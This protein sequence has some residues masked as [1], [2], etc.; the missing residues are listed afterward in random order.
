MNKFNYLTIIFLLIFNSISNAQ[1]NIRV[2]GNGIAIS[3]VGNTGLVNMYRL[4]ERTRVIG[5][6]GKQHLFD[7]RPK[8]IEGKDFATTPIAEGYWK[9]DS[10]KDYILES[11][12]ADKMGTVTIAL[13]TNELKAKGWTILPVSFSSTVDTYYLYTY[14]YT[15]PGTWVNIPKTDSSHP[16]LL[17]ADARRLKF[18]NPLPLADLAEGVLIANN[19]GY[20]VVDPCLIILPNGDYIAEC[21]VGELP[22]SRDTVNKFVHHYLSKDKGKTWTMLTKSSVGLLHS[23]TFYFNDALYCLGDFNGGYGGIVKSTDG[24]QTWT[25]PV[26]LIPEF[27]N[28]PAHVEI[29]NGRIWIAYEHL[30]KPHTINFLSAATSSDLMNANSWISTK[31]LDERSTGNETDMVLGRNG[32]PIAMPKSGGPAVR[33]LSSTEA[34]AD[35]DKFTLPVSGSKYTAKYDPVSDKWWALTSYSLL[36][37]Q[38]I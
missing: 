6:P 2:R 33:A 21:N 10:R 15:K 38:P 30:S 24:G 31:R 4:P 28:S 23:S 22:I 7:I 19:E 9:T 20:M 18:D 16:T 25:K 35:D 37:S 34:K 29:S 1:M 36:C 3:N 27:R 14:N 5:K 17:F 8:A 26:Q 13:N 12:S 32:F 11:F